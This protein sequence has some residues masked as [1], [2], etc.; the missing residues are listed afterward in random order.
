MFHRVNS[1]VNFVHNYGFVSEYVEAQ[2]E[3]LGCKK[4]FYRKCNTVF[5]HVVFNYC[6]ETLMLVS[7]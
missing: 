4:V 6:P 3:L 2:Q 7:T 5:V 1:N